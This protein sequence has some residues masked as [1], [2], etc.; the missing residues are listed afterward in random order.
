MQTVPDLI[1][2]A[3]DGQIHFDE[4]AEKIAKL[5]VESIAFD[6]VKR[7]HTYYME[8]DGV[9][10]HPLQHKT[11]LQIGKVFSRE[12]VIEA[13]AGYDQRTITATQFHESLARAG[14]SFARCYE[15]ANRAIYLSPQGEF[16]LEQ[17]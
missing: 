10:D 1:D 14:V 2:A 11:D 12:A 8:G 6:F 17:W 7:V 9:F 16:H 15:K 5:G 13:I 3:I 4:F